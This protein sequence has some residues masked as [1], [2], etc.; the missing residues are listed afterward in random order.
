M[1]NYVYIQI[2]TLFMF[3]IVCA[4][5]FASISKTEHLLY[6]VEING[7][8]YKEKMV[9]HHTQD[10]LKYEACGEYTDPRIYAPGGMHCWDVVSSEDGQPRIVD[11][12]AGPNTMRMTFSDDGLF[13]MQGF[14]DGKKCYQKRAF[15]GD[16]Y[17]EV[18]GLV[19]NLDLSRKKPVCFNLVRITRFPKLETHNL[20]LQ[21]IDN[22]VIDVPAGRFECKKV[23]MSLKGYKGFF[24]KAY[25][26]VTTDDR[27]FIVRVDN[28]PIGGST[29]L[30]EVSF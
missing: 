26:Y 10:L 14:W 21:V 5:S 1:K 7:K 9:V 3:I 16:V 28:I 11:Y 27:Q 17:V 23:M 13:E 12:Q 2:L 25:F 24:F 30:I 4:I 18:T 6:V 19:R 8:S 22:A 29:E 15:E 20:F